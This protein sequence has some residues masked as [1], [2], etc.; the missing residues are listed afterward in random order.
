[1][2]AL[3]IEESSHFLIPANSQKLRNPLL[4]SVGL[5]D[6]IL[7]AID[8]APTEELHCPKGP[9]PMN[10]DSGCFFS[11]RVGNGVSNVG[12]GGSMFFN[13]NHYQ[14][15]FRG[16]CCEPPRPSLQEL[17]YSYHNETILEYFSL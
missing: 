5:T 13:S 7:S 1:M 3:I 17:F 2:A 9:P 6:S 16:G 8:P 11:R 12:D 14:G 15:G 4:T 10:I